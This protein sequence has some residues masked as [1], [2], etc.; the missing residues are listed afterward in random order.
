M[1]GC[2][3]CLQERDITLAHTTHVCAAS[4]STALRS[5]LSTKHRSTDSPQMGTAPGAGE[6][7]WPHCSPATRPA[8][9]HATYSLLCP[10]A[11]RWGG[12]GHA[13][14][15]TRGTAH[16]CPQS[17]LYNLPVKTALSPSCILINF[18]L[19]GL[20]SPEKVNVIQHSK[21]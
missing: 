19:R 5:P 1:P 11:G 10:R 12:Q 4:R 6:A 2:R 20:L 15:T 14:W 13:A 8:T 3:R 18:A 9:C 16:F 7:C 21:Q 17:G